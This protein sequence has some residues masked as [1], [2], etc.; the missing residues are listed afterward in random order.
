MTGANL[1]RATE[2]V[3]L[4]AGA[5]ALADAIFSTTPSPEVRDAGFTLDAELGTV[6]R[7]ACSVQCS[8]MWPSPCTAETR[9]K[10]C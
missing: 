2:V 5:D 6:Q 1:Y 8:P 7:A 10:V 3:Q 9:L 4:Q